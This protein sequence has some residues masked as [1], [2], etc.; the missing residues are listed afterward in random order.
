LPRMLSVVRV[1]QTANVQE[2]LP[3]TPQARKRVFS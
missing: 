2:P 3:A 1:L